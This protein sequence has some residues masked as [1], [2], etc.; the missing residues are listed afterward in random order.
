[1]QTTL[2]GQLRGGKCPAQRCVEEVVVY[3]EPR[4]LQPF[5]PQRQV[6][7][8]LGQVGHIMLPVK[9]MPFFPVSEHNQGV[10]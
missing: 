3:L 6:V 7:S 8:L 4:D 1:M 5:S 9:G 2:L 10:V